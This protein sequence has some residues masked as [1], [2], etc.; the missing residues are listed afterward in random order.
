[1]CVGKG[2]RK[3]GG[4]EGLRLWA[5]LGGGHRGRCGAAAGVVF[6]RHFAYGCLVTLTAAT[7]AVRHYEGGSRPGGRGCFEGSLVAAAGV[8]GAAAQ[9]GRVGR[10]HSSR[11]YSSS[12][13]SHRLGASLCPGAV[14]GAA[15]QWGALC[16]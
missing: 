4:G 15:Q 13:S 16:V 7:A 2:E 1:M 5:P 6:A 12:S 14:R 8:G 11:C 3:G 10:M 9:A